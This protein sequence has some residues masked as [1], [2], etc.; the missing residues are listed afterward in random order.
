MSERRLRIEAL[1]ASPPTAK[2]EIILAMLDELMAAHPG[3]LL[4]DV[5]LAGEQPGA[6]PTKGYQDKG[7]FKRVPSVFVNGV[8]ASQAE[9]PERG[10]LER[11]LAEELAK[12]PQRWMD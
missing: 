9:V 12:G 10:E 6:T 5:Y 7:K 8:M 1:I 4:V 2:C 3:E 11:L